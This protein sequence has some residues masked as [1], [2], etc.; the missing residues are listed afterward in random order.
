MN[1]FDQDDI[2]HYLFLGPAAGGL[3]V[4]YIQED[5]TLINFKLITPTSPIG[6]ALRGLHV[7]DELD[8]KLSH[9]NNSYEIMALA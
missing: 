3:P 8:L 7:G 2:E 5:Q 9:N 6:K 4:S 1:L